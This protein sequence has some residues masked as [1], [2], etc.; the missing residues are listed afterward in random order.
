MMTADS[1]YLKYAMCNAAVIETA[2]LKIS[3]LGAGFMSGEGLF[4][5]VR[6]RNS[7]PVLFEAHHARLIASLRGLDDHPATSSRGELH[8]R[9]MRVIAANDLVN[10]SLKIIVFKEL[11]GWT[12]LIL[13]RLPFYGPADY[14]RGFQLK[15][16]PGDLRVDPLNS[17][18]SL[19]YLRNARARR[20]AVAAGF[21]DALFIDPT[22]QV[23][24]TASANIFIVKDCVISTP[25][26]G[27]GILPGV[28]RAAIIG[29]LGLRAVQEREVSQD[30]LIEADEVFVTNALLGVMPVSRVDSTFYDLGKNA[31]TRSVMTAITNQLV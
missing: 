23:L 22:Q 3:P 7:R 28:M 17:L 30:E 18:K 29:R 10:G 9:C 21:N 1:P 12:E 26:V 31:V 27:S 4:E 8:T 16:F 13:V 14:E 20:V 5:T 24:E 15:T 19:N 11:T 25:P 6:V 2:A